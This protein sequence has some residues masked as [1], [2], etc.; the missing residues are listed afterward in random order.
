MSDFFL[1]ISLPYVA[2]FSLITV[3][4]YR[5]KSKKFSLS[6]LSSQFLEKDKLFWGSVP[7][8]MG[9][10]IIFLGHVVA[11]TMPKLLQAL[12]SKTNILYILEGIGL[13][14]AM[15]ALGGLVVLFLRRLRNARI[16]AVTS[17]MDLII[18]S[19]LTLQILLGILVA[20]LYRWGA[21]WAPSTVTPYL[22][23]IL[24][25]RPDVSYVASMPL[26]IKAHIVIAWVIILF[27]PFSRLIHIF[28]LP[29][30]YITR[31]PQIVVWNS[32]R[33]KEEV[34]IAQLEA[35]SRRHFLKS[36]FGITTGLILLSI[37]IADKVIPFFR[38][39]S[40]SAKEKEE[41]LKNKLEKMKATIKQKELENERLVNEY[42]YIADLKD[43]K[44]DEGLYF[45]DYSMKPALA[46]KDERGL[47]LLYSA[48]CTHLG[49]TVTN[50]VKNGK[51]LCPCHI[52]HFDVKTG[53]VLDGPAP[54]ALPTV[55]F[56]LMDQSQ[57]IVINPDKSKLNE[58]KVYI[59]KEGNT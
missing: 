28:A 47:P 44:T 58:Y 54:K 23:S 57:Q 7:W 41:M 33:L 11:F 40:L 5:F 53:D 20:T 12:V 32:R 17:N 6:S 50:K 9:I 31:L 25:F 22:W 2:M 39:P 10:G 14:A 21:A 48:K 13:I 35:Q 37:G 29:L 38:G 8:H 52:S 18:L 15:F 49:C 59:I 51:L 42:I 3:T 46:F 45:T 36:A 55:K 30:E 4:I 43:L 26:I 19:L 24:S 34:I 56:I 16:Q 27:M 1:L